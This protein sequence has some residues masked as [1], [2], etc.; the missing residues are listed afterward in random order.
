MEI[1]SVL[2]VADTFMIEFDCGGGHD[3][4]NIELGVIEFS[5]KMVNQRMASVRMCISRNEDLLLR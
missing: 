2:Q 5:L 1:L 3:Y 4:G